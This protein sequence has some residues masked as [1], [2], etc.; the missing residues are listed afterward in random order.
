M[1]NTWSCHIINLT[2]QKF[3][4]QSWFTWFGLILYIPETSIAIFHKWFKVCTLI[5]LLEA[6]S[7]LS[8]GNTEYV[9]YV[10][11]NTIQW[12]ALAMKV[13]WSKPIVRGHQHMVCG[14]YISRIIPKC[15][16][17]KNVVFLRQSFHCWLWNCRT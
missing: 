9:G 11:T 1:S 17:F 7:I 6:L 13:R 12:G 5:N 10:S 14:S 8:V 15:H 2:L 16:C 4:F 3:P